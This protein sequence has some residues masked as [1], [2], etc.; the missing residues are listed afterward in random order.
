MKRP[1]AG[2]AGVTV[3]WGRD[4]ETGEPCLFIRQRHGPTTYLR[5]MPKSMYDEAHLTPAQLE[6][7]ARFIEAASTAFRQP[8]TGPIPVAAEA[9]RRAAPLRRS[10]AL[11]PRKER[12]RQRQALYEAMVS[13]AGGTDGARPL[14][15]VEYVVRGTPDG[16]LCGE[17]VGT[18]PARKS[19]G[20][21]P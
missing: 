15:G 14:G 6:N 17:R 11:T 13:R 16:G 2:P 3:E 20:P 8:S 19:G 7:R 18:R 21:I 10:D 4:P 9:V 12:Q 1:R 5:R